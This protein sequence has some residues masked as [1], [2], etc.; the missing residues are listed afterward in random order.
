MT[1]RRAPP[2]LPRHDG[3]RPRGRPAPV[4]GE[5][6]E[7]DARGLAAAPLA[8]ARASSAW[9]SRTGRVV[10]VGR[11]RALR[12]RARLDL[13][14][15]RRPR[16]SAAT[17]SARGSST[18]CSTAPRRSCER[19]AC[20]SWASTRRRPAA[21]STSS[22]ASR[23]AAA[24]V[25]MRA[26]RRPTAHGCPAR[27]RGL[28]PRRTSRPSS[29]ATASV[30]GADRGAVLRWAFASAPE[31]AWV[32]RTAATTA[33][34][35]GRHGD[36]SDHVGPVVAEDR[37]RSRATSCRACLARPAEPAADPRRPRRAGVARGARRAGLPRAA[38][39]H[40]HVPRR[41]AARRAAGRSS[42]R[43][44]GRSSGEHD[45]PV[46]YRRAVGHERDVREPSS[47]DAG[48]WRPCSRWLAPPA[49]GAA[50]RR[51]PASP[52]S[53]PRPRS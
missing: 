43:S 45:R 52:P 13:H 3:G 53:P 15:P 1:G 32:G 12:R 39:L 27:R 17:A 25:R 49:G 42:P 8:R 18:R 47:R 2:R 38:A 9:R 20:A 24:L 29:P 36:H 7:P 11:R 44:S 50:R 34:C 22:G 4:P 5:R 23:T 31:L 19:A 46:W 28:S 37:R 48:A 6:L 33:Y 14:D 30:F 10:A 41:R 16:A 26:E 35:F 51:R 21:A 40:A